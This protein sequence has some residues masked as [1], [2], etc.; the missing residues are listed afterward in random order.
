MRFPGV[1]FAQAAEERGCQL[2]TCEEEELLCQHYLKKLI[3]FCTHFQPPPPRSALV[4]G[5]CV[6]QLGQSFIQQPCTQTHIRIHKP[7]NSC[8]H[9]H[10]MHIHTP[11]AHT[12]TNHAHNHTYTGHCCCV[13]QTV[14]PAL[15]SD[16][17]PPTGYHVWHCCCWLTLTIIKPIKHKGLN[18]Y[19]QRDF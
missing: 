1:Q 9:T 14:L 4:R 8:T 3:E 6:C 19:S 7:C 2:L 12:H 16:G 18:Y 10:I 17:V 5:L 15:V 11:C 13:L